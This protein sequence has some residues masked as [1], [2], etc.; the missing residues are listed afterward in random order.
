MLCCPR[1]SVEILSDQKWFGE[2]IL[3]DFIKI[4]LDA[5]GGDN[6]PASVIDGA[7]IAKAQASNVE[8]IFVGDPMGNFSPLPIDGVTPPL[9]I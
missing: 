8:F 3:S 2:N 4:A 7:D 5:M 9:N 6:A 1:L